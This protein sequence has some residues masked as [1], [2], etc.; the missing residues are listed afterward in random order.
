MKKLTPKEMR[1]VEYIVPDGTNLPEEI[2]KTLDLYIG[3]RVTN[4]IQKGT[5]YTIPVYLMREW[6]S[7]YAFALVDGTERG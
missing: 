2:I 1:E 5:K 7:K 4:G 6:L 3:V